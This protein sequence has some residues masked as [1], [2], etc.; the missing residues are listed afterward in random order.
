MVSSIKFFLFAGPLKSPLIKYPMGSPVGLNSFSFKV[1]LGPVAEANKLQRAE[2]VVQN[3]LRFFKLVAHFLLTVQHYFFLF[4]TNSITAEIMHITE[5]LI[6][7]EFSFCEI[8]IKKS[9]T[10]ITKKKI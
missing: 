4:I 7:R 9:P 2:E 6:I 5:A 1:I 3:Q 10:N 8:P